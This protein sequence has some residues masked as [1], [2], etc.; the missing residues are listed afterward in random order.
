MWIGILKMKTPEDIPK[1]INNNMT[2]DAVRLGCLFATTL[3]LL[4]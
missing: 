3:F 1:I 4:E 2:T